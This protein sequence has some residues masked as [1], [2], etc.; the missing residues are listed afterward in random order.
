V[1]DERPTIIDWVHPPI[2]VEEQ[3]LWEILHD[4]ELV[5]FSYDSMKCSVRLEFDS[6]FHWEHHKLPELTRLYLDF[7]GVT[8][9]RAERA[10]PWPGGFPEIADEAPELR[11]QRIKEFH[12]KWLSVSM[13][14]SDFL[15]E[16]HAA[17]SAADSFTALSADLLA[18]ETMVSMRFF[19][20]HGENYT[21]W[22]VRGA[23]VA[24]SLSNGTK[25]NV[26]ELICFGK[27]YWE[28]F[29]NRK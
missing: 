29:A 19:G 10:I 16:L 20:F 14:F 26:D 6:P 15:D 21:G 18:T 7:S 5:G 28:A 9:M 1:E 23:A 17:F 11:E 12:S 24:I 2:G 4:G 3:S 13:R 27:S 8:S 25:M 22:V